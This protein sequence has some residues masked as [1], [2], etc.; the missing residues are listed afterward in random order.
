MRFTVAVA[1][2]SLSIVGLASADDV[3]AAIRKPTNISA[4]ALA[5]ALTQLARDRGFQVVFRSEV[6]GKAQTHGAEGK[7]TIAEALTQLLEGTNLAFQYLDNETITIVKSGDQ[8]GSGPTR[9]DSAPPSSR[10]T[11][12]QENPEGPF[13]AAQTNASQAR[14]QATNKEP[15]G[16]QEVLVTAR[17]RTENLQD[18]PIAVSVVSAEVLAQQGALLMQDYYATVP[19]LS[20]TDSGDAGHLMVTMRGLSSGYGNPTVD[21]HRRCA[22]WLLEY[23]HHR[24]SAVRSTA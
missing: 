9:P 16:L 21:Y 3:R 1:I 20:I 12:A 24:C 5:P 6:V 4:G 14:R 19:G 15:V 11:T 10:N 23:R 2:L 17:K 8:E 7:L 13:R 22:D 18:V